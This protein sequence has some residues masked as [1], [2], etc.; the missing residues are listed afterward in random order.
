ME[1]CEG[2]CMLRWK[3][4]TQF[5]T[6]VFPVFHGQVFRA[7]DTAP[8]FRL[9]KFRYRSLAALLPVAQSL[10]RHCWPVYRAARAVFYTFVRVLEELRVVR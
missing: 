9:A 1:R 8:S 5:K 4:Q 3:A 6:A 10:K 7:D 2:D